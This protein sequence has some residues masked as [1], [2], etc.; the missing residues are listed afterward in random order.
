MEEASADISHSLLERH[1][2]PLESS[3]PDIEVLR[4]RTTRMAF[5]IA[6]KSQPTPRKDRSRVIPPSYG[7]EIPVQSADGLVR[8]TIDAVIRE[9]GIGAIIQDYKSGSI[10]ELEDGN[11]LHPKPES[12]ERGGRDGGA[13]D[14]GLGGATVLVD[15]GSLASVNGLRWSCRATH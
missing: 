2:S 5:D 8:G 12:T 10:V 3:V 15:F 7:H 13:G 11:E 14:K 1:L 4:I 9:N 6:R